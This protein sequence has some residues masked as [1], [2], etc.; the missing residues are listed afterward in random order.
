MTRTPRTAVLLALAAAACSSTA[1]RRAYDEG[2]VPAF[3]RDALAGATPRAVVSHAEPGEPVTGDEETRLRDVAASWKQQARSTAVD[4]AALGFD[5]GPAPS[6]D[7]LRGELTPAL[8]YAAAYT[9]SPAIDASRKS[10]RATVQQFDQIAF[11]DT[12]LRQYTSFTKD[13]D[14]RFGA[15]RQKQMVESSFPFPGS[16]AL[17]SRIVAEDAAAARERLAQT[18]RDTLADAGTAY[19]EYVYAGEAIAILEENVELLRGTADVASSKYGVGT[20]KQGAV[21]RAQVEIATL[22]DQLV[23]LR[24]RLGTARA[25]IAAILGLPAEFPLGAPVALT[26]VAPPASPDALYPVAG[27]RRQEIRALEAKVRRTESLIELAE[28]K[29]YP[30]LSLGTS[31]FED[32]AAT[33]V[34]GARMKPSFEEPPRAKP[35]FWFGETASFVQEMRVRLESMRSDLGGLRARVAFDV[36]NAWVRWDA[37]WRQV[38]LHQTSL[39]PQAR[40]A[41]EVIEAGWREGVGDYLDVLDAQ[42]TWLRYRLADRAAVRD[43]EAARLALI[44][45]AGGPPSAD[46]R[47]GR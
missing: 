13:L 24:Q 7:D 4:P 1:A 26:A 17:K 20:A 15:Q 31:R 8:L 2:A 29:A 11:L 32:G 27:R 25:R 5:V 33:R 3:A 44:V 35:S 38:Q 21:L 28:T 12:L 34:G 23:T 41:F 37:A 40:Q 10:L 46:D 6:Q 30:D 16:G 42:R 22:E 14:L 9:M 18:V 36:K 43:A 39:L 47:E 45:A 19:A